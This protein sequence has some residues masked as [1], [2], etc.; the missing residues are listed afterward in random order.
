MIITM[1]LSDGRKVTKDADRIVLYRKGFWVP[2]PEDIQDGHIFVNFDHVIDMR[3]ADEIE[4]KH[5]QIHGW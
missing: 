2:S 5:A 4:Q 1:H 3:P